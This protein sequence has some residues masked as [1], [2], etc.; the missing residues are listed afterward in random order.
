MDDISN[1]LKNL[2]MNFE[3]CGIEIFGD[4]Q[5]S[6]KYLNFWTMITP[7]GKKF[8]HKKMLLDPTHN[9]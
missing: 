3:I 6:P 5:R 4:S 8:I 7:F 9:R 2:A 1:T